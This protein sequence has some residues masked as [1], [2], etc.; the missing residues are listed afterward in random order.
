[1]MNLLHK[2][3]SSR[4]YNLIW[5]LRSSSDGGEIL[6]SIQE[7]LDVISSFDLIFQKILLSVAWAL[8][9]NRILARLSGRLNIADSL[10][11]W[12]I[13]Q[14]WLVKEKLIKSNNVVCNFWQNTKNNHVRNSINSLA[15][16]WAGICYFW[17][18]S[19]MVS[20]IY[21]F[22]TKFIVDSQRNPTESHHLSHNWFLE[23]HCKL[24]LRWT[25]TKL[26]TLLQN[27]IANQC[28]AKCECRS[29]M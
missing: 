14:T 27:M 12:Q 24:H 29:L 2:R 25:D 28:D 7:R 11:N 13:I 20:M 18:S 21:G 16:C 19:R 10:I 8:H 4:H 9:F 15:N 17:N 22:L 5:S 1:M 26:W 6:S 23:T 3:M